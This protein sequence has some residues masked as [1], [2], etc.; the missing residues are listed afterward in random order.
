METGKQIN[1]G[2]DLGSAFKKMT[3]SMEGGRACYCNG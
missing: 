1:G 2:R 3:E